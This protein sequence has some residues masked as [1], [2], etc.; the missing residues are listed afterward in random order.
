M[1]Y[2]NSLCA[3]IFPFQ[4]YTDYD[5]ESNNEHSESA[6]CEQQAVCSLR[7]SKGREERPVKRGVAAKESISTQFIA[8]Q[9]C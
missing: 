7:G 1:P 2:E 9:T 5:G 8:M 4:S 3:N 6:P